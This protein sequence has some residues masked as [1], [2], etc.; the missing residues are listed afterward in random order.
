MSTAGPAEPTSAMPKT[1]TKRAPPVFNFETTIEKLGLSLHRSLKISREVEIVLLATS[2]V[3]GFFVG[4]FVGL[5]QSVR[6]MAG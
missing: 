2:M 1:K 3:Q 4:S 5:A 6:S